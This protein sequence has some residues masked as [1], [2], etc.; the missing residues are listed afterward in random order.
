MTLIPILDGFKLAPYQEC[1]FLD[2]WPNNRY[3]QPVGAYWV[4]ITD[5]YQPIWW[6]YN[7]KKL[8][9]ACDQSGG[10]V[11]D[12]DHKIIKKK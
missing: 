9:D 2:N 11:L 1:Y 4:Y 7:L 3:W 12:S 8:L 6:S 5:R 10:M